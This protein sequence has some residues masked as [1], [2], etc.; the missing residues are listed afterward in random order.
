MA[1]YVTQAPIAVPLTYLSLL[2]IGSFLMRSVTCTIND[3]VDRDLD[4]AV[5]KYKL[6]YALFLNTPNTSLK[7]RTKNRPMARGDVTMP[8]AFGF[9]G[10]QLGVGLTFLTQLNWYRYAGK[11]EE[12]LSY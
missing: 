2:G 9:V 7:E 6:P 3:M 5:G 4:R 11:K 8:Q 10:A 1:A 12:R